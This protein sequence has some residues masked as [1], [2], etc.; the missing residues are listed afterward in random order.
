MNAIADIRRTLPRDLQEAM[1]AAIEEGRFEGNGEILLEA[2][3]LWLDS[4]M[5]RR[6]KLEKLRELIA[7]GEEGPYL[8]GPTAMAELRER[9][10]QR[11][12]QSGAL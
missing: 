10:M 8:D 2:L 3:Y 4:E 6:A 9:L 7:E 5:L 11:A 12:K 1:D